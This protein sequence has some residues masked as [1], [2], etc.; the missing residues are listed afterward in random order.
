MW[1]QRVGRFLIDRVVERDAV[2]WRAT[3]LFPGVTPGM[4]A[5]ARTILP[6]GFVDPEQ[7]TVLLAQGSHLLRAGSRAVLVDAGVG[8]GKPRRSVPPWDQL[9]T[10]FLNSLAALGLDPAGIDAVVCTHLH[11]DHVGW[12]T[13]FA[14]GRWVPTFPNARVLMGRADFDH[15][16]AV[17]ATNPSLPLIRGAWTDSV[18]PVVDAGLAAPVAARD[19][20]GDGLRLEA[21]PGHSPGHLSLWL[22]GDPGEAV[23]CGDVIISPLQVAHPDLDAAS[24]WNPARARASRRALLD[25]AADTGALLIPSHFTSPAR[26][27]RCG[28]GY[29]LRFD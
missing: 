7:D 24:D 6:P 29:R 13:R 4:L 22:D 17:H 14:D 25:R 28:Q 8:N 11:A 27:M 26:V 18:R 5:E 1:P 16:A 12:L 3:D 23:F 15:W 19:T 2:P 10:S 21:S 20:V 9:D